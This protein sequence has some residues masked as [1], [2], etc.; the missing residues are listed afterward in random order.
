MLSVDSVISG[1]G[2]VHDVVRVECWLVQF[3]SVDA[4]LDVLVS[5][6]NT[7]LVVLVSSVDA[8]LVVPV[9]FVDS[10]LVVPGDLSVTVTVETAAA[11]VD[12]ETMSCEG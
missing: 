8:S 3:F 5:S 10:S 9:S 2:S 11:V 4:S 1:A 7:S 6:V 12:D